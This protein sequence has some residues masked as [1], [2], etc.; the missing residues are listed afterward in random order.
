MSRFFF[1]LLAA[2]SAFASLPSFA[3]GGSYLVDDAAITP[4]SHCQLES[5][6]QFRTTARSVTTVPACSW[7]AVEF[8]AQLT[9]GVHA[10]AGSVA[11]GAKWQVSNG[12]RIST[13]LDAGVTVQGG[14]V[15]GAIAYAASTVQLDAAGRWLF[16]VNVGATHQKGEPTRRILGG[17]IEFA[18]SAS[19]TLLAE[20]LDTAGAGRTLQAGVRL[21][22]GDNSIDLV[23]GRALGQ[24]ADH[25]INMGLNL[26][27]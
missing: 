24:Q 23:V 6:T 4:A 11:P 2:W 9:G 25:W 19:A 18:A 5:W 8:S 27:F 13:A 22:F 21:P 3:S 12:S 7:G 17:G 1:F 26:A 10:G 14:H 16:N 15:S 20:V